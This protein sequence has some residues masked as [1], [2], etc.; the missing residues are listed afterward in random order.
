M[1]KGV[2]N[3]CFE[4]WS[5]QGEGF[6][7]IS[8]KSGDMFKD[9]LFKW[10]QDREKIE[11]LVE[12]KIGRETN[13]YWAPLVFKTKRR[14]EKQVNPGNTLYA[15]LDPVNPEGLPIRPTLAWES[16]PGRYQAL[17]WLDE[18]LD[19]KELAH[20]NKALTYHV[21]AD[22]GGWDLTQV[23]RIPGTYNFKYNPPKKGKLLWF[24]PKITYNRKEF[25]K[26]PE[27]TNNTETL[28]GSTAS[29]IELLH[30]YRK[31]IPKKV[32][33]LLQ[34]PESRVQTGK[35]SDMLWYIESELVKAQIPL[36]DVVQLVGLSA[37]NK[38]QGRNDEWKRLTTEISKIYEE[39]IKGSPP[40][41]QDQD[42]EDEEE[43]G[44]PWTTFS[45]LMSSSRTRPGYL[46]RDIWLRRSH[47]MVAGEPKTFKST[48]ALDM[49]VSVAS[50]KPLWGQFPVEDQGPVLI[51]QNENSEWIIK[52][53][54]EK[55][56]YS[57]DLVGIATCLKRKLKVDFPPELPIHFLNNYGYTF[58]DPLH[59][60]ELEDA[61]EELQPKLV[62]LDPLYLMFDGEINS[63][64][65]L[66]PILSWLLELKN[67][68]DTA[69]MVVHHW[70]KSGTSTRGGQ[71]M[72][73]STTLHGWVESALYIESQPEELGANGKPL[74]K[75]VIEREL[76]GGGVLPKL[77]LEMEMGDTG[78][79]TYNPRMVEV[80]PTSGPLEL[81][82]LLTMYPNGIST[83]QAAKDLG[84]SR[85][86]ISDLMDRIKDKIKIIN[87]PRNS[88]VIKLNEE[89][90]LN[91]GKQKN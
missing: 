10:P 28:G 64:K 44:L 41:K 57:K 8:E 17:W 91:D 16:S 30:R 62:I 19:P 59:R 83:S 1:G 71:R 46:I 86:K 65:E 29:L 38:Y 34:Y 80:R 4:T 76:R 9:R 12:N 35:R 82:D 89:E 37:W 48:V 63:A 61:I 50:G 39:A 69:I 70:N 22:P 23:L 51:I 15:D 85:R 79:P 49:A 40:P 21:K 20:L 7:C 18:P 42:D 33:T 27:P 53:R 67:D 26:I 13:L 6:V 74:P 84:V 66:N 87:G 32:S 75:I 81:L 78:D 72:L 73:G 88:T 55:I 52:D 58:S 90:R 36:E 3:P 60:E 47:G 77:A 25:I 2:L 31:V 45:Q 56:I 5:R 43:S 24:D 14:D 54:M 11:D 68:F